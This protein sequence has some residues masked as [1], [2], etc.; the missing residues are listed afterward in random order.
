MIHKNVKIKIN[1]GAISVKQPGV[2]NTAIEIT[3]S[4]FTNNVLDATGGAVRLYGTNNLT[5]VLIDNVLFKGNKAQRALTNN[6]GALAFMTTNS[7]KITN[8]TFIDNSSGKY[9][10]AVYYENANGNH[11]II[12]STFVGNKASVA[13]NG[14]SVYS[15]STTIDS[16]TLISNN[17]STHGTSPSITIKDSI[18]SGTATYASSSIVYTGSNL[19]QKASAEPAVN[20]ADVFTAYTSATPEKVSDSNY[21]APIIPNGPAYGKVSTTRSLTV[22][23]KGNEKK[24]PLSDFG[25]YEA[26][27][28]Y[29]ATFES[30][31]GNAVLP[32]TVV[33]DSLLTM[34]VTPT[35]GDLVFGSWFTD[36]N[37]FANEWNFA[38]NTS[39][40]DTT[41]YAKWTEQTYSLTFNLNGAPG[42]APEAQTLI[43][44][45][46]IAPVQNPTWEGYTFSG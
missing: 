38:T 44:E 26:P 11:Q 9:G 42:T 39:T 34:P 18:L 28:Y 13:G 17:L 41:L 12:N 16:S 24:S 14:V 33:A 40:A 3:N 22:A 31:G 1:G 37:T 7:S 2:A 8:C 32:Q 27:Q 43:R 30:N 5:S 23:Q 29:T 10:G 35:K 19:A 45:A 6:V 25:A 15:S 20:S 46:S 4:I 36:N 21:V